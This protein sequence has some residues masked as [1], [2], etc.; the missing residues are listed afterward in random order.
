MNKPHPQLVS[1]G[2]IKISE[3]ARPWQAQETVDLLVQRVLAGTR[4]ITLDVRSCARIFPNAAAPLLA[5]ANLLIDKGLDLQIDGVSSVNRHLL[6]FSE[7]IEAR[8]LEPRRAL[9]NAYRF[10]TPKEVHDLVT[11]LVAAL[12]RR[13]QCG[14]G[15]LVAFEWCLNEIADNVIQHAEAEFGVLVSLFQE[16]LGRLAICVADSGRG[17]R[18]SLEGS[19]ANHG[20]D[21]VAIERALQRGVTRDA[22]IHQGNG[23]WGLREIVRN[24]SGSLAVKSGTAIYL[25]TDS[26]ESSRSGQRHLDGYPG[27][28]VDFQLNLSS[29]IDVQEALDG[30]RPVNL[31]LEQ[32]ESTSGEHVVVLSEIEQGTGTRISGS[33]TRNLILNLLNEGARRVVIDCSDVAMSSSFID[34]VFGMLVSSLGFGVYSERVGV[35]NLTDNDAGIMH[36]VVGRRLMADAGGSPTSAPE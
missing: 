20:T 18:N 1:N 7:G 11:R 26:Q 28:S 16:D 5:M 23:L 6:T 4:D 2:R 9:T 29:E 13:H 27:T 10:S 25:L 32:Y 3:L 36:S 12:A 33:A 24:N 31:R 15:V 21:L 14:P 8:N 17:I 34:E 19:I 30:H 35:K 22:S